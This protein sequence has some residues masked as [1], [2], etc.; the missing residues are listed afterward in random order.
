MS[1]SIVFF[2]IVLVS[3]SSRPSVD[4]VFACS[5]TEAGVRA[6]IRDEHKKQRAKEHKDTSLNFGTENAIDKHNSNYGVVN[7]E[8]DS[9]GGA[10]GIGVVCVVVVAFCLIFCYYSHKSNQQ[11]DR[12]HRAL[13][14]AF[15]RRHGSE[16][17]AKVTVQYPG[18]PPPASRTPPLVPASSEAASLSASAA[19]VIPATEL[20]PAQS[21]GMSAVPSEVPPAIRGYQWLRTPFGWQSVRESVM[22]AYR[23]GRSVPFQP[24]IRLP[25]PIAQRKRFPIYLDDGEWGRVFSDLDAQRSRYEDR[26]EDRWHSTPRRVPSIRQQ[27]QQEPRQQE[28][29]VPQPGTESGAVPRRSLPSYSATSGLDDQPQA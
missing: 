16:D 10:I 25:S 15:K 4:P 22:D 11:K 1:A 6:V 14:A 20:R 5:Y 13:L 19:T 21:P 2:V 24:E 17:D 8:I 18:P 26:Y 3:L 27:R 12:R 29:R 7:L 28:P 23:P 9:V